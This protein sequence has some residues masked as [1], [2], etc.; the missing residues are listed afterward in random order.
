MVI[1]S[2]NLSAELSLSG[3]LLSE[4]SSPEEQATVIAKKSRIVFSFVNF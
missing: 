3:S 4:E 2:I 1:L